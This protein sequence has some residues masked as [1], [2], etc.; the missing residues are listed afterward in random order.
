MRTLAFHAAAALPVLTALCL[1]VIPTAPC[2]DA[3]FRAL[4]HA[5][6]LPDLY[7]SSNLQALDHAAILP[8]LCHAADLIAS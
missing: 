8:E 2:Y 3:N 6:S 1:T 4:C 5:V 7:H